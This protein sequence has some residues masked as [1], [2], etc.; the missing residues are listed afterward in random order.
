MYLC[1]YACVYMCISLVMP[2][3]TFDTT[4]QRESGGN[5]TVSHYVAR[6]T[7]QASTTTGNETGGG[8]HARSARGRVLRETD[9]PTTSPQKSDALLGAWSAASQK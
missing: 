2:L 3:M 5:S 1:I 8:G 6:T 9:G 7:R 4:G